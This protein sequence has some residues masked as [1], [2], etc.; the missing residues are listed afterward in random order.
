MLRIKTVVTHEGDGAF[1]V[2]SNDE[3]GVGLHH[4]EDVINAGSAALGGEHIPIVLATVASQG[5]ERAGHR[6]P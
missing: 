2:I 6:T 1:R 5:V 3:E 4:V